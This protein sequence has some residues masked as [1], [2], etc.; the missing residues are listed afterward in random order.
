MAVTRNGS[1]QVNIM[2]NDVVVS[3]HACL[4]W[5]FSVAKGVFLHIEKIRFALKEDQVSSLKQTIKEFVES[6][7]C[8]LSPSEQTKKKNIPIESRLVVT[9]SI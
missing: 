2:V 9:Q 6:I 7:Q 4:T 1:S 3:L 5:I 8:H